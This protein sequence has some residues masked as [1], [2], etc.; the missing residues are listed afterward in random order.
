MMDNFYTI[1]YSFSSY[2]EEKT[3]GEPTDFVNEIHIKVHEINES[4]E[5]IQEV[6]RAILSHILF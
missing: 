3:F 4:G 1:E 6:G 5:P 2:L